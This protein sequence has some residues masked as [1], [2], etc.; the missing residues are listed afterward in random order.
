VACQ[1]DSYGLLLGSG[2]FGEALA[3]GVQADRLGLAFAAGYRAALRAL[4]PSVAGRRAALCATEQGSAHPKAIVTRVTANRVTGRKDF[5][6]FGAE[7]ELLLVVARAED[8]TLR[9]V[10]VEAGTPG[11]TF[12]PQPPTPFAPELLHAAVIFADAPGELLPGDGYDVYLKP[13]RTIED[14]HVFGA[15]LAYAVGLGR[16]SGWGPEAIARLAAAIAA[17]ATLAAADPRAAAT[18]LALGGALALGREL[19]AAADLST[20]PAEERA[21]WERD[22]P[23]LLVAERVRTQRFLRAAAALG[24]SS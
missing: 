16:R 15:A 17:F 22:R 18:H 23:L 13:F 12:E 6:T 1:D 21:R 3:G 11:V 19:L 10:A 2:T 9:L 14:I 24:L 7:A 20:A 4:V 8:E 5:V